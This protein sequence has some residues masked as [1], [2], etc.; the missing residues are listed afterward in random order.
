MHVP[1]ENIAAS[2]SCTRHLVARWGHRYLCVFARVR[3]TA[4]IFTV[5]RQGLPRCSPR[6]ALACVS[7]RSRAV[8]SLMRRASGTRSRL[9]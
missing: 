3:F 8:A 6:L 2:R 5:G 4:G 1:N 9:A 7:A